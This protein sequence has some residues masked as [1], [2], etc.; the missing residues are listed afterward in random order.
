MC[1]IT[2]FIDQAGA[3]RVVGLDRVIEIMTGTLTHRGP[4]DS[5]FWSDE[6]HQIALG[7]RRLAIVDLSPAGHQ[8]MF[9]ASGRYVIV[10]NGEIYSHAEMRDE[11]AGQGVRFRGHSDTEVLL[12]AIA[13]WGLE[14]TLPRLIGMFAFALWDRQTAELTLVRDRLGIKPLYWA[15]HKGSILFASELK[16]FREFPGWQPQIDRNAVAAYLRHNYIPA[17]HSIYEDVFKLEPGSILVFRAGD[18]PRSQK[19]WDFE[20]VAVEG[21]ANRP[22]LSPEDAA[23]ALEQLLRDAVKRCMVADVP[24]GALLSGGIDSSLVAALMQD[25]SERPV[26]TFSI[27]FREGGF[28]E[29]PYARRIAE[30]IG[31]D[32]TELYVTPDQARDVIPRLPEMFD[33]PFSDSSQIPTYLVCAMT[34]RSVTVALS[35]DGGD[36][37]FAGYNRYLLGARLWRRTSWLPTP[38]RTAFGA[39]INLLSEQS[40][41]QLARLIPSSARPPQFGNKMRKLGGGLRFPDPDA[42]YRQ[43]VSH[44]HEPDQVVISGVEPRGPLWDEGYRE[45]IPDFMERMQFFDTITY[46]PDDILTKVDRASMAASLEARVPLL[47]HR[48]VEFAWRLPLELKMREGN[49]KWILREIL[50]RYVP[51]DLF[52]RPKMGF[53]VPI[54]DWLRGPLRDWAESLLDERRL[55]EQGLLNPEPVRARWNSHLRGQNAGYQLWDV[56]MLQ[57]WLER[58]AH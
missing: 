57:A 1:G 5:G 15:R 55:R 42:I 38:L 56:L 6:R 49:G 13:C 46:L 11:L 34:R 30:H 54:D 43:I 48:V 31:S 41:D 37:L 4:D 7:H 12:E 39:G 29:A 52:D 16:A 14:A 45:K 3:A 19:F 10:Y 18:D 44:W 20:K 25:Q 47:D 58:Y 36:E 51:R 8:P 2:G 9:S 28:D 53:G 23:T 27:G 26:R 50:Q 33:E 22:Q 32:H 17:P 35:G 40:W 24:L 21:L